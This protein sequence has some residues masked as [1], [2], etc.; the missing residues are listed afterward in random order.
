MKG[1]GKKKRNEMKI[2]SGKDFGK[3]LDMIFIPEIL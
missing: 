2:C 1:N 3:C